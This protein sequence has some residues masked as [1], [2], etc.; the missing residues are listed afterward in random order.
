MDVA[1]AL[2]CRAGLG[3]PELGQRA[4]QFLEL[5]HVAARAVRVQFLCQS[6]VGCLRFLERS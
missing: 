1:L 3:A 6:S 2:A 5:D 4:G